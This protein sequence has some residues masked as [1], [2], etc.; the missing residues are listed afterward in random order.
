[1]RRPIMKVATKF[2]RNIPPILILICF[3]ATSILSGVFAFYGVILFRAAADT[4]LDLLGVIAILFWMLGILSGC[5]ACKSYHKFKLTSLFT[6]LQN[7]KIFK[8]ADKIGIVLNSK[9]HQYRV[10]F[11]SSVFL[12]WIV[13]VAGTLWSKG[14][15]P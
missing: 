15:Q 6:R 8:T 2:T 1:M 3:F 14:Y 13:I 5:A 11:W 4:S 7:E 9:L 12:A 10:I